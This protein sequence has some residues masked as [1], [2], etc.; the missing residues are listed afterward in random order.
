MAE[1]VKLID[2]SKCTGCRGCQLACKQW[3]QQPAKQTVNYGSYQNPPDL[4]ENTW[5]LIRFQEV[6][7]KDTVKWLF[8][9]DGCMHCTDAACVKVCPSGALHYTQWGTVGIHHERCIGCKECVAACPFHIPRYDRVTDKVYK[10]D[11][12]LSRIEANLLP[13]CVKACPTG[14][15]TFGDKDKMIAKAYARVK[16]LGGD[17][18]VYG[19]KFVGGTHVIYVLTEKP[20]VYEGLPHNPSVPLTVTIWKDLLKPLSLLAAGGVVA[21]SFLHYIIHGPKLPDENG[22]EGKGGE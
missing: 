2:V 5:T 14:A 3:N 9:K 12:C 20:R 18:N 11:L 13:A 19:D 10:C 6:A 17:A 8:R 4:Q 1:K 22:S 21:G 16:E 15:L 7:E